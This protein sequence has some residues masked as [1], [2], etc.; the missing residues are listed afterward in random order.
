ML[1]TSTCCSQSQHV[2]AFWT[3]P[4]RIWSPLQTERQARATKQ[5]RNSLTI[6][7]L[8]HA[9]LQWHAQPHGPLC[10]RQLMLVDRG[11][12]L[13]LLLLLLGQTLPG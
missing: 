5:E 9:C 3:G 4:L 12:G 8:L 1:G 13:L 11:R 10:L 6:Q 7:V 2:I